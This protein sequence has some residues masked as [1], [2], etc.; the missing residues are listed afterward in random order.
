MAIAK[1]GGG[2]K[3]ERGRARSAKNATRH[4]LTSSLPKNTSEAELI[5]SFSKEL[6]DYCQPQSPLEKLQIARIATCRAK[7]QYLY[8]IERVKLALAAKELEAQ[9]EKILEKIPG[10]SGMTLAMAK[11]FITEGQIFLPFSLDISLLE[12][13]NH[14]IKNF[15]GTFHNK[16]EFAR[17]FP[18]LT[19]YLNQYPVAGL[20]NTDQWL[21]KLEALA[22]QF[23]DLG[24]D[25]DRFSAKWGELMKT[26]LLGIEYKKVLED[27]AMRPG[28][29]ELDRH[30][31]ER[32]IA[33]GEKP[34]EKKEAADSSQDKPF[35][36]KQILLQLRCFTSLYSSYRSAQKVVE[37]YRQIESLM[38]RS[39]SLPVA[40]SDLLMRYQTTLE[41]RLSSAIGELLALQKN[42]I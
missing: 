41:R 42:R 10:A 17:T 11:E 23:E 32:R 34:R 6:I 8:E 25:G 12:A 36:Q 29:E 27:E 3:T 1:R 40:E 5:E 16:Y 19:K 26:F 15:A 35:D 31:E 13:I 24:G 22:H 2:P 37:Q 30:Q 18:R 38:Q 4:G 20:N 14:E 7:L 21:E 33:R 28:L 9:P 39:L